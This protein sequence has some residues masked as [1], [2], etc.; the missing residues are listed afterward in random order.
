MRHATLA[1]LLVACGSD[2]VAPLRPDS[3]ATDANLASLSCA[4]EE[5][6]RRGVFERYCG[7]ADCHDA[8]RPEAGMDLVTPG[9]TERLSNRNSVIEGCEERVVVV[10][11]VARASFML[12]KVLATQGGCGDPMP[13]EGDLPL[14]GRRCLV[15]WIDALE[16]P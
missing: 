14:E 11:G 4:E 12:D 3:G 13:L 8:D 1:L 10:P 5:G 7:D 9:V 15:E 6:V 16:A 2:P